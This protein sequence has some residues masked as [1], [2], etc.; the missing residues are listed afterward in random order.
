MVSGEGFNDFNDF[1]CV[2]VVVFVGFII[3]MLEFATSGVCLL[4]VDFNN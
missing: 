2:K 3:F 1:D 4:K